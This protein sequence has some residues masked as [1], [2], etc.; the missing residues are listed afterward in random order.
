MWARHDGITMAYCSVFWCILLV[1]IR[2]RAGTGRFDLAEVS[3]LGI[4]LLAF[5]PRGV[6]TGGL[7]WGGQ[8][9]GTVA[10]DG[11]RAVYFPVEGAFRPSRAGLLVHDELINNLLPI[12]TP[13]PVKYATIMNDVGELEGW[14]SE[15]SDVLEGRVAFL[16]G[17]V[18][19]GLRF[20][21][22]SR[23]PPGIGHEPWEG[24]GGT[25][26]SIRLA[27]HQFEHFLAPHLSAAQ[28]VHDVLTALSFDST[29]EY[30][31]SP[32][33]LL[34]SYL[35]E[36]EQVGAMR[37]AAHSLRRDLPDYAFVLS[38]PWAPFSFADLSRRLPYAGVTIR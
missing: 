27:R 2:L 28:R 9:A 31:K 19:M 24:L 35:A 30:R 23:V 37:R 3:G 16:Q 25:Q 33:W 11:V 10:N 5:V 38:G 13:L 15:N 14:L 17:K 1:N 7:Q 26:R 32:W 34:S 8:N 4:Y 22:L 6:D 36:R 21:C 29:Y 12:C 20:G 18:E